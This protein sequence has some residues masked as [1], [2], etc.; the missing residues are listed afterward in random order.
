MEIIKEFI[1]FLNE[2]LFPEVNILDYINEIKQLGE[3]G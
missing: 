2:N 1:G 3:T